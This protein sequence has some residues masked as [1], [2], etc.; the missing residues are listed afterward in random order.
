[1][2]VSLTGSSAHL[3]RH[4]PSHWDFHCPTFYTL[5]EFNEMG[6]KIAV[7]S[8]AGSEPE[9]KSLRASSN[10]S[11]GG[12]TTNTEALPPTQTTLQSPFL[13]LSPPPSQPS[14]TL[15]TGDFSYGDDGWVGAGDHQGSEDGYYSLP[16]Q[17]D[18]SSPTTK[19]VPVLHALYKL[20]Q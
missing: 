13:A 5:Q 16:S 2:R 1:M 17:E 6:I 20:R 8:G 19:M 14:N 15:S 18:Q 10:F 3:R 4:I 9:A 12:T 11:D 7:P